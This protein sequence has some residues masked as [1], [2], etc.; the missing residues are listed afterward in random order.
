M[1]TVNPSR[2]FS[3]CISYPSSTAQEEQAE[4]NHRDVSHTSGG[5]PEISC[6]RPRPG[7]RRKEPRRSQRSAGQASTTWPAIFRK[8]IKI[9]ATFLVMFFVL[10]LLIDGASAQER[11]HPAMQKPAQRGELIFDRSPRPEVPVRQRLVERDAKLSSSSSVVPSATPVLVS[12]TGIGAG[13]MALATA[14]P[15]SSSLPLPFD[16]SIGSNF[17]TG[18]GCPAFFNNFLS[19]ALFQSCYPFSLLLQVSPCY[20]PSA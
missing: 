7:A 12:T 11:Y 4:L 10:A 19:N 1:R 17:T 16:T 3:S 20:S 8:Y 15:S 5:L 6:H 18:S 9:N 13:S 2:Q 14:A